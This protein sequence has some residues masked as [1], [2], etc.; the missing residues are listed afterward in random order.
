ML[1]SQKLATNDFHRHT[2]KVTQ[3]FMT[4]TLIV[5]ASQG[6]KHVE[7]ND[8]TLRDNIAEDVDISVAAYHLEVEH[9]PADIY[10]TDITLPADIFRMFQ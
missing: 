2:S 10:S 6:F 4:H 3:Y 7:H 9:L 1:S 5:K 8:N